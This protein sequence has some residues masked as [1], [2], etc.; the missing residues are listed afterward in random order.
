MARIEESPSSRSSSPIGGRRAGRR[1]SGGR[2]RFVV[3]PVAQIIPVAVMLAL[4]MLGFA[5]NVIW[6]ESG[7]PAFCRRAEGHVYAEHPDLF[8]VLHASAHMTMRCVSAGLFTSERVEVDWSAIG[9]TFL[10][11]YD[12]PLLGV[13]RADDVGARS[14]ERVAPLG[15]RAL[16]SLTGR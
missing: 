7:E 16:T 3:E 13:P 15:T 1:R 5:T 14:I 12:V 11:T 8:D 4:V 9:G 2:A 6:R 10:A